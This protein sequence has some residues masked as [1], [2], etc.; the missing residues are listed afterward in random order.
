[1]EAETRSGRQGASSLLDTYSTERQ[2]VGRQIVTR[3]N[4]SIED[5]PPIFE[6]LG[7]CPRQTPAR[8][9]RLSTGVRMQPPTPNAPAQAE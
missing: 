6:A 4:K 5:Y 8:R 3:A 1:M 2:P 7:L 9:K